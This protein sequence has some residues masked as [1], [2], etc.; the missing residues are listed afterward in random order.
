M[1][2]RFTSISNKTRQI[3]G[4]TIKILLFTARL[5]LII[6]T[7]FPSEPPQNSTKKKRGTRKYTQQ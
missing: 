1:L 6:S 4:F 5:S 3:H 2:L 7:F